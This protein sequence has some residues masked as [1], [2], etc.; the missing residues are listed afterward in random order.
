M[1]DRSRTFGVLCLTLLTVGSLGVTAQWSRPAPQ[2]AAWSGTYELDSTRGD[3]P[4]QVADAATIHLPTPERERA[5]KDLISRL[6]APESIAFLREGLTISLASTRAPRTDFSADG[7]TRREPGDAGL[8]VNTKA[9]IAGNRLTITSTATHRG[10]DVTLVFDFMNAGAGLIVTRTIGDPALR[11]PVS[12]RGFYRRTSLT[13]DWELY[14]DPVTGSTR[15]AFLDLPSGTRIVA[16]LETPISMR[17][18]RDAAP[19]SL[20]V[21]SPSQYLGAK[22]DGTVSRRSGAGTSDLGLDFQTIHHRGQWATFEAI[23]DTITLADGRRIH[24]SDDGG[25]RS[26]GRTSTA[27]EKGAIGAAVGAI[28]GAVVGGTRSAAIGAVLGGAGGA[29]VGRG[30]EDLE[31]PVGTEVAMTVARPSYGPIG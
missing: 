24:V 1:T 21:T 6:E 20:T 11:R 10:D 30:H 26:E 9:V 16:T 13:P 12:A 3:D 7:R 19:I 23:V 4:H 28:V 27:V 22:I 25:V 8:M 18:A 15:D 17:T 5:Y 31:M 2:A 29:I 14:G